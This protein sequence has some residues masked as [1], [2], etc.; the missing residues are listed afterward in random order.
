MNDTLKLLNHP[1][2][3]NDRATMLYGFGYSEKYTS[4]STQTIVDSYI[5]RGNHNILVVDW[6]SYNGN[7]YVAQAI[8]NSYSVGEFV[9]KVLWRMKGEGFKLD[10]FHLVGHSLGGHLVGFIGRNYI[11]SSNQT[12]AITRVTALDPAGP[13]FYGLGSQFNKPLNPGDGEKFLE[14]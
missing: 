8:V 14:N 11:N 13:L 4:V 3:N 2:Y 12:E 7:R 1:Y 5:E 9:G 10:K 6:S